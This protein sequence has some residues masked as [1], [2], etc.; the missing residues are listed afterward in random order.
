M[1]CNCLKKESTLFDLWYNV[2]V[3]AG[4]TMKKLGKLFL[5]AMLITLVACG[6]SKNDEVEVAKTQI[7]TNEVYEAPKNAFE[8]QVVTYNE[9]TD[10]L[11]SNDEEKIANLVAQNFAIDFFS[12]KNKESSEDVGGLTYIPEDRR[13]EWKTFAM[14]YVY[15]NYRFISDDYGKANLPVVSEA[16]VTNTTTEA[17][18]YT[19]TVPG[20]EA[21][22][23]TD[24]VETQDFDAYVVTISISY[25]DTSVK[26]DE[27]KSEATIYV[28]NNN[29]RLEII[30]LQ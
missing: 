4:G 20:N 11:K 30:K 10:A 8:Y 23:T 26:A 21:E 24:T 6:G 28:I 14:N 27:L 1:V 13:E 29:G 18:S 12:L 17:L 15:A 19:V 7:K 2:L 22:G 16:K 9:L 3:Y 5:V 25:E